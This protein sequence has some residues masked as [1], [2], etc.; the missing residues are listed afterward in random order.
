MF[1]I[2]DNMMCEKALHDLKSEQN[3]IKDRRITPY[4][5]FMYDS[6]LMQYGLP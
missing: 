1:E 4:A 5:T 3:P 6:M 2:M